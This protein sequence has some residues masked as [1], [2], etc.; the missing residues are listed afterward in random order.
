MVPL[1][2]RS[3]RACTQVASSV[4]ILLHIPNAVVTSTSDF[5]LITQAPL[6]SDFKTHFHS[7]PGTGLPS[8]IMK[9]ELGAELGACVCVH[10]RAR[11]RARVRTWV[12]A[13]K[14]QH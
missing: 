3:V 13:E 1:F 6:H 5:C 9:A 4:F 11:T 8:D 2:K 7:V 14:T 12:Y 10:L